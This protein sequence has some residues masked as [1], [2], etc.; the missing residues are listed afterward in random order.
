MR[1]A[2]AMHLMCCLSLCTQSQLDILMHFDHH[3]Q[4]GQHL[5][6][7]KHSLTH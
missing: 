2:Q 6:I 3:V 7:H 5:L 4:F 1:T